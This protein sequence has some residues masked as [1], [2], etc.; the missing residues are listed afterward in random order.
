MLMQKYTELK[1]TLPEISMKEFKALSIDE[2]CK[3]Q[4]IAI[5]L[6]YLLEDM[7]YDTYMEDM[8]KEQ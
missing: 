7:D 1:K 4:D 2:Q 8:R 3:R 5:Q 6:Q